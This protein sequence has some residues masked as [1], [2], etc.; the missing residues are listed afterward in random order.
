[1]D[2]YNFG[3][4]NLHDS[5]EVFTIKASPHSILT[6]NIG[7]II[8]GGFL[9]LLLL[10]FRSLYTMAF[11]I[12]GMT[13]IILYMIID[14]AIWKN[15]GIRKI[16]I[17]GNGLTIHRGAKNIMQRIDAAQITDI[18]VFSKLNR[19]VVNIMLGGKINK[20]IP[21]V[22]FFAGPRIRITNDAFDDLDF[23]KL[24]ERISQFKKP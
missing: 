12:I 6:T 4:E 5:S 9:F 1:M 2:L 21:G 8:V 15:R 11:F 16:E 22:T 23:V 18:D 3:M 17:D 24:I 13:I 19:K 20:D 10:I 14:Y 7:G